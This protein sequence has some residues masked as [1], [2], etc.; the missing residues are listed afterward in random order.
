MKKTT[1]E[2]DQEVE[3]Q[4][5]IP[6]PTGRPGKPGKP[7]QPGVDPVPVPFRVEQHPLFSDPEAAKP[8]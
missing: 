7:F 4:M 8:I 6:Q 5:T 3:K 1:E 2:K